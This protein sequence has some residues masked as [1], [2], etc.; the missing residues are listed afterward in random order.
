MLQQIFDKPNILPG[1]SSQ[2]TSSWPLVLKEED[3]QIIGHSVG[4]AVGSPT[5]QPPKEETWDEVMEKVLAE[6]AEAWKKLAAL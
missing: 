6:Y 3:E 2:T 4:H 5:I 1:P